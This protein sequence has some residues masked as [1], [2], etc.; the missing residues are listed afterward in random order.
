MASETRRRFIW[1]LAAP[2]PRPAIPTWLSRSSRRPLRKILRLPEAHYCLGASYLLS[3]GEVEFLKAIEE[4]HRELTLN[5]DGYF[6]LSQLGYIALSQHRLPEAEADLKRAASLDP[7]NP[8]NPLLLGQVYTQ[9]NR[10]AEAE[11]GLPARPSR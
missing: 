2:M 4:F 7:R 6:S 8:D 11:A 1:T 10:P 3:Q 9:L 5:P